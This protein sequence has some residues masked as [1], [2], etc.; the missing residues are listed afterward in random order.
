MTVP[1]LADRHYST[2]NGVQSI[3]AMM[4]LKSATPPSL[5]DEPLG[6]SPTGRPAEMYDVPSSAILSRGQGYFSKTYGKVTRRVMSQMDRSGTEDLGNTARLLYG[7]ILSNTNVLSPRETSYVM[8][9]GLIPQDVNAQLKGHLQ[10]SQNHGSTIEEVK[11]VREVII[12]ICE[13]SGMKVLDENAAGGWG[14]K[15]PVANL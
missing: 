13:A 6:Y 4:A 15:G 11:A 10:G 3:N 1:V 7:Y 9:A 2:G 12:S 8:L 5:L 14:W